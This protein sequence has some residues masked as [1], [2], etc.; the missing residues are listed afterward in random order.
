[1]LLANSSV[2]A[3]IADRFPKLAV[4]RCH[5]KPKENMMSRLLDRLHPL[6]YDIDDST[7]KSLADSLRRYE[8]DDSFLALVS[9]FSKPMELARYFCA[10]VTGGQEDFAHHYALSIDL[11]THF[12]SPIRRY[13]DVLVHRLLDAALKEEGEEGLDKA[14]WNPQSVERATKVCNERKLA[15]KRAGEESEELFLG[16]FVKQCGRIDSYG[17]VVDV[18]NVHFHINYII[19]SCLNFLKF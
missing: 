15:A 6:G 11:Y 8:A 9:M 5:P 17:I 4:L 16:L 13:P 12:T 14:V 2:A 19:N 18:S 3:K 7:S 1:M 10:G